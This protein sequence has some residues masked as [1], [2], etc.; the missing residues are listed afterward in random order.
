MV[1]FQ[2]DCHCFD[3]VCD[4]AEWHF[5]FN[6]LLFAVSQTCTPAH[7]AIYRRRLQNSRRVR[8]PLAFNP[9]LLIRMKTE[10]FVYIANLGN[11]IFI[12]DKN[13]QQYG[14][15]IPVAHI[16]YQRNVKYLDDLPDNVKVEIEGLAASGNMATSAYNPDK[17]ALCPITI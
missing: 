13:R 5:A 3:G 17:F 9:N 8:N 7:H 11:G 16:D 15:H 2:I 14:Y 6:H 12:C 4:C 1:F 10:N